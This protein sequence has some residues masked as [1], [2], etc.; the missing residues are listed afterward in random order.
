MLCFDSSIPHAL[1]HK[2]P[3]QFKLAGRYWLQPNQCNVS[4]Y[5]CEPCS[6]VCHDSCRY[7]SAPEDCPPQ[8]QIKGEAGV[9]FAGKERRATEK[10]RGLS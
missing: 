10:A 8:A 2:L 5:I 1:F 9:N 3:A 6:R 4:Q 7:S